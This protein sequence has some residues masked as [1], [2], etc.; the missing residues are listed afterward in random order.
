[1]TWNF[2][3]MR[4]SRE[5]LTNC[6]STATTYKISEELICCDL[7]F[8][9]KKK[10][11]IDSFLKICHFKF[12][13]RKNILFPS[14]HTIK[15]KTLLIH[16]RLRM[17]VFLFS[18]LEKTPLVNKTYLEKRLKIFCWEFTLRPILFI[19][20]IM[21]PFFE[22]LIASCLGIFTPHIHL[23]NSFFYIF[24][25]SSSFCLCFHDRSFESVFVCHTRVWYRN[26][27]KINEKLKTRFLQFRDLSGYTK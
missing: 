25:K 4:I 21:L 24:C 26:T 19:F 6:L 27:E 2:G 22:R 5:C 14:R 11:V 18:F 20:I 10:R 17:K 12:L 9:H 1:M 23:V 8:W 16:H 13:M 7:S 3:S 15:I